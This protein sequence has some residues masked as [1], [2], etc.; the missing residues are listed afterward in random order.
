M[1]VSC[2]IPARYHATRLYGKPIIDICG[3]PMIWWVYNEVSKIKAFHAIYLAI[4]D[5]KVEEVCKQYK[6][7]YIMTSP[8][9]PNHISR[10]YEASLKTYADYYICVNGDEPL[11]KAPLIEA[12]FPNTPPPE[13]VF[14]M[15]AMKTITHPSEVI[16]SAK[17]KLVLNKDNECIYMSRNPIPYPKSTLSVEYKK[18]IGIECFNKK[19]LE[20]F[21]NTPM[22]ILEK[23]EDIDHLRFIEAHKILNFKTIPSDSISVDTPKDL[24][25]V[26]RLLKISS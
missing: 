22:G 20:F 2:I 8:N 19:A 13:D 15:G 18:Y 26:R 14:F 24:E 25:Q 1:K 12:I 5:V 16:D 3:K 23:I 4:D 11:L 6:M 17:I 21:I 9:H 7:N 10:L